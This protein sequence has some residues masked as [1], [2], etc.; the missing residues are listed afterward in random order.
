MPFD[1]K[2]FAK[3]NP[4][5]TLGLLLL[6]MGIL[7]RSAFTI[8]LAF[9]IIFIFVQNKRKTGGAFSLKD[10]F[11]NINF[12]STHA[13]SEKPMDTINPKSLGKKLKYWIGGAV[14]LILILSFASSFW[15]VVGAGETGVKSLFGKVQDDELRS[16]FHLKNP[17]VKVTKMDI[18]TRDYTMSVVKGEGNRF[19]PDAISA[20][21]KEGLSVD[22]D[23]TVLYHLQEEKASDV[24]RDI[25]LNYDEVVIRPQ[26]RG[27]IREIIA[28][29]EA[30]D[31]YSEKRQQAELGIEN[32][33][34]EKLSPRGIELEDVVLRQV[35]LPTDLSASI[36][37]K[38]RSEQES[39]R[40]DFVL[41]TEKKEAE[42]KRVEA[43]GQRD[44]QRIINESLSQNYLNYLYIQSLKD[45]EG[46]VYVPV[47]PSN[48][49]PLFRGL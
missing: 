4:L 5:L 10:F 16:G 41:E 20:L 30:K 17:F 48:G 33:L 46:T 7:S 6:L 47:N 24:Y 40:Y 25:G 15:V 36:Q 9:V 34:K 2:N 3:E 8:I 23:I 28:Q 31:I 44:A 21:T 13:N 49:L 18:R 11:K 1:I 19:E 22:L 29:Y 12:N 26:I 37:E 42:R 27:A 32:F 43:E 38:L 45:R 39:Q 35:Q 14:V